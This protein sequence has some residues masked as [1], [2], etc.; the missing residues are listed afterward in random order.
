MKDMK[1]RKQR[2]IIEEKKGEKKENQEK[3]VFECKQI[4]IKKNVFFCV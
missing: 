3:E 4:S 1:V 2:M